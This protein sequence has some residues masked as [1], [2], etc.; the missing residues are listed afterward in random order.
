MEMALENEVKRHFLYND[1][2]MRENPDRIDHYLRLGL[3]EKR[4][5]LLRLKTAERIV[6]LC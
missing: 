2:P 3:V 1:H 5:Q 4:K 6:K